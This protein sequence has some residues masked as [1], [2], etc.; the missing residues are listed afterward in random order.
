MTKEDVIRD[1]K[2]ELHFPA[3]SQPLTWLDQACRLFGYFWSMEYYP[4]QGYQ[5]FV[6]NYGPA[7][8]TYYKDAVVAV[9]QGIKMLKQRL[10]DDGHL[11]E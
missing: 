8:D 10:E 4:G 1:L 9:I 2:G 7:P 5:I 11:E 3:F 6:S